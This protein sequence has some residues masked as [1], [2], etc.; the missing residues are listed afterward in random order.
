MSE[1]GKISGSD[2]QLTQEK[3]IPTTV[4][5]EDNIGKYKDRHIL[6]SAIQEGA[7]L[8]DISKLLLS[9]NDPLDSNKFILILVLMAFSKDG[10]LPL[11]KALSFA[12]SDLVSLF[13][14]FDASV[15]QVPYRDIPL[16]HLALSLSGTT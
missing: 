16:T 14:S 15:C 4:V 12:R 13:L 10:M 9:H 2:I 7:S 1:E 3:A 6:S 5:K 11:H 8:E